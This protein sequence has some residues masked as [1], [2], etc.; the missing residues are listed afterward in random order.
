MGWRKDIK[1]I[2]NLGWVDM[3]IWDARLVGIC[4]NWTL[5]FGM[6][7]GLEQGDIRDGGLYG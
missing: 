5:E 1:W 3:G 4:L 2:G 7:G 6:G